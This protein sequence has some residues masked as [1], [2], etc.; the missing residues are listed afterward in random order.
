MSHPMFRVDAPYRTTFFNQTAIRR[1]SLVS[2]TSPLR[3]SH[4]GIRVTSWRKLS[5]SGDYVNVTIF[6]RKR[7]PDREV[8]Q[9]GISCRAPDWQFRLFHRFRGSSFPLFVPLE[10]LYVHNPRHLRPFTCVKDLALCGRRVRHV[11]PALQELARE[12][13]LE[14]LPALQNLFFPGI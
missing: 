3:Q 12:R 7:T 8:L 10:L 4:R 5:F 11:V 9:L 1:L 13:T 14:L 6:G 2:L